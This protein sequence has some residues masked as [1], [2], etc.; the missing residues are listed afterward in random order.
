MTE[1]GCWLMLMVILCDTPMR[2]TVRIV[3]QRLGAGN[4]SSGTPGE[5]QRQNPSGLHQ[6]EPVLPPSLAASP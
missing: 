3:S 2:N 6:Q 1:Y 4:G 5:F